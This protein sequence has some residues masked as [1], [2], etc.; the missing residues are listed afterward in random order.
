MTAPEL[1]NDLFSDFFSRVALAHGITE[2]VG[3]ETFQGFSFT[4]GSSVYQLRV[5]PEDPTQAFLEIQFLD[6]DIYLEDD[7]H[8]S[9][10]ERV[11]RSLLHLNGTLTADHGWFVSLDEQ[12]VLILSRTVSLIDDSVESVQLL[13]IDGLQRA[14]ALRELSR[15]LALEPALPINSEA[16]LWH[17]LV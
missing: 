7:T 6:L 4:P 11:L 14:N 5:H 8:K 10:L 9:L 13:A 16:N 12:E 15:G 2:P 17:K 3:T 1:A